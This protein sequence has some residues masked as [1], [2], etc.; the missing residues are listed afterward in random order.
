MLS[1]F[2]CVELFFSV[3][4]IKYITDFLRLL[5]YEAIIQNL[6][7]LFQ[8]WFVSLD[9]LWYFLPVFCSSRFDLALVVSEIKGVKL[10]QKRPTLTIITII[11]QICL[12]LQFFLLN[13]FEIL[14]SGMWQYIVSQFVKWIK[15]Y[16][17]ISIL[18]WTWI[19]C[20]K[21]PKGTNIQNDNVLAHFAK[22][23][24]SF[25]HHMASVGPL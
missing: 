9:S 14:L 20:Q 2:V 24:M 5:P 7:F 23:N 8:V 1:V 12:H 16:S 19:V 6:E 3:F 11:S 25:C 4:L 18:D 17:W 13:S 10:S 15:Y 21:R 22:G